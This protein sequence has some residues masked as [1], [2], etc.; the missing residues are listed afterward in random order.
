M[1]D[2]ATET[3]QENARPAT[4]SSPESASTQLVMRAIA[5][6]KD[7]LQELC[8]S[9]AR[10]ILFRAQRILDN[11]MDAEDVAQEVLIK[12]CTKIS[13]LKDPRAFNAWLNSILLHESRELM[14]KNSKHGTVLS[15]AEYLDSIEEDDEDFL[16]LEYTLREEERKA[17]IA[18]I[19]RLSIRQKEAVLLHY[20]DGLSVTETAEAMGITQQGASRYLKLARERVKTELSKPVVVSRASASRLSALPAGALLATILHQDAT[21]INPED[22]L[23][24]TKALEN[25]AQ[26]FAVAFFRTTVVKQAVNVAAG[27]GLVAT[28]AT[29]LWAINSHLSG[30]G[31]PAE[32]PGTAEYVSTSELRVEGIIELH[33]GEF[34]IASGYAEPISINPTQAIAFAHTDAGDMIALDW[35]ITPIDSE[36]VLY[37]GQG[38]VVSD[39]LL[40]LCDN[41]AEGEYSI[42]FSMRDPDGFSCWLRRSFLIVRP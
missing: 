11:R 25:C 32:S 4:V 31:L 19:D 8:R 5:G 3:S 29:G 36:V 41:H 17:I 20:F 13:D 35:W 18:I 34:V 42:Y 9:Y 22:V 40:E 39:C 23:W 38:N 15:V 37:R 33:G 21:R 1:N 27:I 16:P 30:T 7:A 2:P 28:I 10:S 24:T 26:Y 14:A 12:M 6:D